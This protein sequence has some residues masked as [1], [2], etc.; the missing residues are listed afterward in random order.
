MGALFI[1]DLK[2]NFKQE[3]HFSVIAA[4]SCLQVPMSCFDY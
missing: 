4:K 1:D 3:G 2:G